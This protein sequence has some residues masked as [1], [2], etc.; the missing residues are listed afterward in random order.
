MATTDPRID[1]YI[2]R[3]AAFAPPILK[4]LR[5]AVHEA[6]PSV[7]E[8]IKW[9]MPFFV[10]DGR[11]FAN[12]AAFRQHCA[13]GFWRGRE[14]ADQ[15]KN[16]EA[17]GQF[18][19]IASPA[20]LPSRRELVRLIRQA[21]AAAASTPAAKAAPRKAAKA[22]LAV[23]AELA[24]ALAGD[25]KARTTFEAMPPS[26][27]RE[28]VEWISEAKRDETRARRVAQA[29]AWLAEGKSRNWKYEAC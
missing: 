10:L 29:V 5:D 26:H 1:A 18:G 13:F 3:A 16:G 6:C 28:Y 11:P 12:M 21:A 23:P 27:R 7:D 14:V 4:L 15:G 22:P 24:E 2:E 25:R 8:T 17:M 9:S 19:R 20:D